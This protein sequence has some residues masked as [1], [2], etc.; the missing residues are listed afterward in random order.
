ERTPA[1]GRGQNKPGARSQPRRGEADGNRAPRAAEP[2]EVNGNR[3]PPAPRPDV[4]GNRIANTT[5]RT[6]ADGNRANHGRSRPAPR[7]ALF[8]AKP[9]NGNR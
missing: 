6:D 8:S 4:D 5:R 3:M 9:G 1:A 7:A 2:R